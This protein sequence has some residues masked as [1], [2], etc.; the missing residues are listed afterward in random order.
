MPCKFAIPLGRLEDV[1]TVAELD[2]AN[3]AGELAMRLDSN[4]P[5]TRPSLGSEDR[6]YG[7]DLYWLPLGA[8]GH[9]VRLNG[10]LYEAAKAYLERRPA[11]DL[12]HSG[13]EVVV[14]AGRYVIEMTPVP[15]AEAAD[16][17]VVADGPVGARWA[18]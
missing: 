11:C 6:P 18:G 16:R 10:R 15:H 1:R 4:G 8:G 13:L 3:G 7:I 14:P 5:P 17:G 12:Y 9:F 2:R